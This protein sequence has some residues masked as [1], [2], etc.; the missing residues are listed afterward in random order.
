MVIEETRREYVTTDWQGIC[1]VPSKLQ[2]E[3]ARQTSDIHRLEQTRARL[4]S[5]LKD[6]ADALALE[7]ECEALQVLC[8]CALLT[9]K[10]ALPESPANRKKG[11]TRERC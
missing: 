8:R 1:G 4:E 10:K 6:K 2:L 9:A 3:M 11:P 5:D 7:Q